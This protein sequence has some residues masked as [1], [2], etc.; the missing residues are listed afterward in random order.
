MRFKNR[1]V[2]QNLRRAD[3]ADLTCDELRLW[4][5]EYLPDHKT[6]TAVDEGLEAWR[7]SRQGRQIASVSYPVVPHSA[8]R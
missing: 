4:D 8:P 7:K 3:R 2:K 1:D 6:K 5:P